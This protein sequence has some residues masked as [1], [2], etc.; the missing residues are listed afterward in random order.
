[1]DI[2]GLSYKM[3]TSLGA[4]PWNSEPFDELGPPW[5]VI[6]TQDTGKPRAFFLQLRKDSMK[7]LPINYWFG[8]LIERRPKLSSFLCLK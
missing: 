2:V 5:S 6:S 7:K 4:E 1:M 8:N 3:E